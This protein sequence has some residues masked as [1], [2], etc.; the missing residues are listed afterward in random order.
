MGSHWF[1]INIRFPCLAAVNCDRG[2]DSCKMKSI[3]RLDIRHEASS[4]VD[5]FKVELCPKE[6]VSLHRL[7]LP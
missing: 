1:I 3:S 7:G 4:A 6:Q 2:D 5:A